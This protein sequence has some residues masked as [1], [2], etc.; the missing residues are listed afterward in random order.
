M[1]GEAED[2]FPDI[3]KS[4]TSGMRGLQDPKIL[5]L[6]VHDAVFGKDA[7]LFGT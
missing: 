4:L 2:I 3:F 7:H 6:G 5:Y 1:S